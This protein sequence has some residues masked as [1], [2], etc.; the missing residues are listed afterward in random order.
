MIYYL[1]DIFKKYT[2]NHFKSEILYH[3]FFSLNLSFYSSQ[4]FILM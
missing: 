3:P 1:F 2:H 4:N